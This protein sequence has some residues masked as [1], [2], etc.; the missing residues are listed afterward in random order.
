M[1]RAYIPR[2]ASTVVLIRPESAG[3]FEIFLTRRPPEMMFLGGFYVFPGGSV[4]EEDSSEEM[5]RRC[6]GLSRTEA[7]RILGNQMSPE[8]SLGHWVAAVRELFEEAGVL[9]SVYENG[10]LLDAGEK[11]FRRRQARK[12]QALVEGSMDF[13]TFLK[14][15]GFLCDVGRLVYFF[16]RITPE[17]FPIR[18]DARFYLALLPP[19]QMALD[20][21]EEVVE[22]VWVTPRQALDGFLR[23]G[24][25]IIPPTL[26]VLEN[27]TRFDSWQSLCGHYHLR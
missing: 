26:T 22:S 19:D 5:L 21:S 8:L 23:E 15:E 11:E 13:A 25:Q 1:K 16:H 27:L 14:S 9:L 18:F 10:A 17:I 24:L 4:Q 12:R 3:G 7:Q 20:T 2:K 6:H